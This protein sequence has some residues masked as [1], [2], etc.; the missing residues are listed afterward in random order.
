M[1]L[2][3][4]HEPR[5]PSTTNT[6]TA[7]AARLMRLLGPAAASVWNELSAGETAQL[8]QAMTAEPPVPD[9][10]DAARFISAFDDN[11]Q[12]VEHIVEQVEKKAAEIEA[13]NAAEA[14]E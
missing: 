6:G 12:M 11:E 10:G 3:A 14:A 2:P 13:R 5:L 9:R 4:L 7:R 8:R 1:T